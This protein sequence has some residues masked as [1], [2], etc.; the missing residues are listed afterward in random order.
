MRL[1]NRR[2]LVAALSAT[3]FVTAQGAVQLVATSTVSASYQ[4]L[5]TATSELLENGVPGDRLGGMGSAIAYAGG[6][7]FL[8]LP[9]RGPNAVAGYG[10]GNIDYTVSYINRFETFSLELLPNVDYNPTAVSSG[11]APF[12]VV[13]LPYILSPY[14]Q[15]TTLLSS[16]EPLVYGPAG[17]QGTTE[18]SGAPTRSGIPSLNYANNTFYS[19]GG[20]TDSIPAAV[21]CGPSMLVLI[22]KGCGSPT[23][24]DRSTFPTN[25]GRMSMNSTVPPGAARDTSICRQTS[26]SHILIPRRIQRQAPACRS[27]MAMPR[28]A[29]RTRVP[30][31][32]R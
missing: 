21:R 14:L 13:G 2:L 1:I 26:A 9:D 30:R 25:T 10:G 28:A 18:I 20:R 23:M 22:P 27:S 5:S 8:T 24:D 17:S 16:Q 15:E 4:D 11:S 32:S 31:D 3:P 6:D 7:T 19:P 12:E 29:S